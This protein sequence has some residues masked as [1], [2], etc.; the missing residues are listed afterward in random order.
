MLANAL[1]VA[2]D[3]LSA[4]STTSTN[5]YGSY[6]QHIGSVQTEV[7]HKNP[8]KYL[9]Q[10]AAT[11]NRIVKARDKMNRDIASVQDKYVGKETLSP[12]ETMSGNFEGEGFAGMKTSFYLAIGKDEFKF[13][14]VTA[15]N[16]TGSGSLENKF[17]E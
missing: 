1:Y 9:S 11:N 5:V 7:E 6:G 2:T 15:S 13:P 14:L 17:V 12:G 3:S 8:S 16:L 10:M 4:D